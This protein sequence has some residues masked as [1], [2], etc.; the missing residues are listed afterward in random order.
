MDRNWGVDFAGEHS[1]S[2]F[3]CEDLYHGP[4]PFSEEETKS[5]REIIE[6]TVGIKAHLDFQSSDQVVLGPWAYTSKFTNRAKELDIV[7][8]AL[9]TSMGKSGRAYR[10]SRG[11]DFKLEYAAS[12]TMSDWVFAP[13]ILSFRIQFPTKLSANKNDRCRPNKTK[14][15]SSGKEALGAVMTISTYAL[16]SSKFL[17]DN[18]LI[19]KDPSKTES[20]EVL[21]EERRSTIPFGLI[22]AFFVS[23]L[24]MLAVSV[25]QLGTQLLIYHSLLLE[26]EQVL[27]NQSQ[28]NSGLDSMILCDSMFADGTNEFEN[29]EPADPAT[30]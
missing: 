9:S 2:H 7:G 5:L 10:Y 26:R 13:G 30:V 1:T 16:D 23:F 4:F 21:G 25:V 27:T 17:R 18:D 14:I 3:P 19:D 22:V 20:T 15:L 24:L 29:L 11:S 8:N 28:Q 6:N 12:G